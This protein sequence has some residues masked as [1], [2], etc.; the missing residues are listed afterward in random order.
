MPFFDKTCSKGDKSTAKV[1]GQLKK[2][3]LLGRRNAWISGLTI[4]VKGLSML[5]PGQ[6]KLSSP[7]GQ[8][9]GWNIYIKSYHRP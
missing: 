8:L 5:S 4:S 1:Y 3:Y 6:A 9:P 7:W 2:I